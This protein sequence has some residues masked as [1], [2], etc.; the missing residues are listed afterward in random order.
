MHEPARMLLSLNECLIICSLINFLVSYSS[1]TT[2]HSCYLRMSTNVSYSHINHRMT[3]VSSASLMMPHI[4][5]MSY[6]AANFLVSASSLMMPHSCYLRM[7]TNVLC[8][9]IN[10]HENKHVNS[11]TGTR[12]QN[13]D[14]GVLF[15][16]S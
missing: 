12:V 8:S 15:A 6:A 14:S 16:F 1:R 2:P 9:R 7:R 10:I 5:R 4:L 3:F 11:L 13:I